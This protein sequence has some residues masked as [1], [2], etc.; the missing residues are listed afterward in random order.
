MSNWQYATVVPT[1]VWRSAS[2]IPRE[3]SI[4]VENGHYFLTSK[5]VREFGDLRRKSDTVTITRQIFNGEKEISTGSV[6]LMQ[7]ELFFGFDLSDPKADTIGIILE[8]TLNE[9]LMI[10]YSAIN[11]QIYIDR[12]DAG[13]P[14]FSK[15]FAGISSAPYNSG[16]VLKLHLL[17]DASSVELFVDDGRLVMTNLVFPAEK[18]SRLGLFSRGGNGTLNKAVFHGVERIWH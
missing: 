10:G 14:G 18:F 5:P 3:L 2:T 16:A 8:N 17:I 1:K 13:Y 15:E 6:S 9:K 4:G 11:K 7:S 12:R